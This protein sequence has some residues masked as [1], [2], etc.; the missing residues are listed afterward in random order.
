MV[1]S[2]FKNYLRLKIKR[3]QQ[4]ITRLRQNYVILIKENHVI[5]VTQNSQK[6]TCVG[7]S[8]LI[9][10]QA[11]SNFPSGPSVLE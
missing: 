6:N 4:R 5:T 3:Q 9:K 11:L 2:S 10:F 8:F 7:A 1:P